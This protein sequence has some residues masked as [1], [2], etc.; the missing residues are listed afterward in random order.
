MHRRFQTALL[1][2]TWALLGLSFVNAPY[3]QEQP[4]Q[5]A[6]TVLALILLG[7]A[8]K[9]GGLSDASLVAIIL[10]AWAHI[11]GARYIYSL[12]PYDEWIRRWTGV[13]LAETFHFTRNHYDRFVHFLFGALAM[14]PLV[15]RLRRVQGCGRPAAEL[16]AFAV[17]LAVGA[18]YEIFEWLLALYMAPDWADRY[19][20]Q[21]GD[22]WDAQ[23]DM[24]CAALGSLMT[25]SV[26]LCSKRGARA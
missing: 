4:L 26:L 5:N 3:L 9:R 2:S 17:A 23:K 19:N 22:M 18:L 16:I 8:V 15:Q 12:V 10:F 25:M 24:S 20:G 21:Q 1:L 6:P 11:L 14:I 13:S 7:R